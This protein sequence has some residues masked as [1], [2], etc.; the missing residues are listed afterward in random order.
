MNIIRRLLL[1]LSAINITNTQAKLERRRYFASGNILLIV[2]LLVF[3]NTTLAQTQLVDSTASAANTTKI[4]TRALV[5]YR[6]AQDEA[7]PSTRAA[8]FL[9]AARLFEQAS[10]TLNNAEL[11]SNAGTA[12]LQAGDRGASVVAFK[13]ALNI[14]P[15]HARATQTL[16]ELRASL[17]A[18]IPQPDNNVSDSLFSWYELLTSPARHTAMLSAFVLTT[19]LLAIGI[20]LHMSWLRVVAVIPAIVLLVLLSLWLNTLWTPTATAGVLIRDG[21]IARTSDSHNATGLFTEAL[22]A[23]VEIDTVEQRGRWTRVRFADARSGWIRTSALRTIPSSGSLA[24]A[25]IQN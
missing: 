22:P 21:T 17:P 7:E 14:D 13:R 1:T 9:T 15:S 12:Y 20:A 19:L 2:A 8:R 25:N 24:K 5:S 10:L 6:E 23:G 4:I 18:W 3:C 16:A 11:L